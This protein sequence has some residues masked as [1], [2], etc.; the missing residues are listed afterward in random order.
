LSINAFL[1]SIIGAPVFSLKSFTSAALT[2]GEALAVERNL[3][4]GVWMRGKEG[5]ETPL[6]AEDD[7]MRSEEEEAL[8]E[9][10]P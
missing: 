8:E 3:I 5:D 7:F 4:A 9:E 2:E 6:T 10:A 1:H